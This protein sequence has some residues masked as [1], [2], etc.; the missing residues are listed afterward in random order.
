MGA[1]VAFLEPQPVQPAQLTAGVLVPTA[2][3]RAEGTAGVVF[4]Y[5]DGKVERRRVTLGETAGGH[6]QVLSGLRE[7]ERVVLS[8]PPSL[9]DSHPVKLSENGAT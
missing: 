1:R 3:V 6:R 2:S 4:V 9:K 8:P 7:G 5:A